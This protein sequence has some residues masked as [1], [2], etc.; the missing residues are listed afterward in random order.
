[1]DLRTMKTRIDNDHY[2]VLAASKMGDVILSYVVG[3][4]HV[5]ERCLAYFQQCDDI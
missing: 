5:R 1:M 2:E 3:L 4:G